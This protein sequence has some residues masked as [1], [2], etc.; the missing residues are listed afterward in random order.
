[1]IEIADKTVKILAIVGISALGLVGGFLYWKYVGCASGTC[2]ITS[3]P[4]IS[5][6]YGAVMGYLVSGVLLK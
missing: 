1:M 5:S 4:Y 2:P 3:N 6:G